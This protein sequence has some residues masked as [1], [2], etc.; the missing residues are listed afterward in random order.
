MPEI[1]LEIAKILT[2][3]AISF[4]I[5]MWLAPYLISLL[6][7]LKFWK[8]KPRDIATTGEELVVTKKFYL[9][10]ERKR[11]VPRA[12]GVLIWF[13]TLS[14]ATFFWIVLKIDPESKISQFL[15]FVSRKETFI[16]LGTLFFGS[17]LGLVDDI[18]VTMDNGGNYKA[19]GLRLSQRLIV[20]TVISVLIGL[21]FYFKLNMYSFSFFGFKLNLNNLNFLF[22]NGGFLIIPITIFILITTWSTGI[23]DGFDGLAT[24]VLI[25]VYICFAI[26]A[27]YRGMYDISTMMMVMTGAMTA[28]LWFNISPAKFYL[29][30][31][32]TVGILLNL[33]VVAIIINYVYVLFIAGFILF[34]TSFSAFIQVFSK[35]LFKRKIFLAAP[36][37][38][39]FEAIGWQR[40]QITIRYWLI[41]WITSILG[42]AVGLIF[43]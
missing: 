30:D 36:I 18:L 43:R 14:F 29:G 21:W 24:G 31:T 41:S 32:G 39:H 20:V 22:L 12:G 11:L 34:I 7:W 26:L 42:L 17:M 23:I 25:P 8:K 13:V 40:Q 35:K 19:G 5:A 33:A 9:E 28:Y 4:V 3:T 16:P 15:N 6:N 10:N 1:S 38:H 2:Y 27:F 37:H